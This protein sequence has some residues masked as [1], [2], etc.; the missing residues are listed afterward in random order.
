RIALRYINEVTFAQGAALDWATYFKPALITSV[1]AGLPQGMRVAKSMHQFQVFND[2]ATVLV[3]YGLNNPDFP[4][5]LVRRQFVLD[6]DAFKTG[7]IAL[8]EILGCVNA[9]NAV[10]EAT[11]EGCIDQGLRQ[12]MG[13]ING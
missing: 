6:I 2:D 11:F 5:E 3:H 9:L 4:N 8:A 7:P 1:T 10:C 13:V 12:Q